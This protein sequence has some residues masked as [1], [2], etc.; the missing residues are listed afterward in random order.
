MTRIRLYVGI[1]VT[2]S[3]QQQSTWHSKKKLVAEVRKEW[4][5]ELEVIH[6]LLSGLAEEAEESS[7]AFTN[8]IMIW[9]RHI[10]K[11]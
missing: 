11:M 2:F 7:L 5:K 8:H 9:H 10:G 1:T 3:L 4:Q 6:L